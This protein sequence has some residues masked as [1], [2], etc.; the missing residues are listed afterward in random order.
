MSEGATMRGDWI[1]DWVLVEM[2]YRAGPR[3]AA[4]AKERRP[5]SAP[6]QALRAALFPARRAPAPGGCPAV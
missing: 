5:P 1:H 3:P 2:E 4:A 6:W